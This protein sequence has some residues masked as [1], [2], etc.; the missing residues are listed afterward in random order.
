[1]NYINEGAKLPTEWVDGSIVHIYENKGNPEDCNPYRP[2]RLTQIIYKLRS[3]LITQR[4]AKI[5]HIVKIK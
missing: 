2:I 5:L 3:Q 1:M 4:L